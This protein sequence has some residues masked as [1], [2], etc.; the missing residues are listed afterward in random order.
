MDTNQSLKDNTI[1]LANRSKITITGVT[2]VVSISPSAIDL[3]AYGSGLVVLGSD[4][5][6]TK[7]NVETGD[8]EATGRFDAI[9]YS[10]TNSKSNF[11]KRIFK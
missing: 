8:I 7:L 4:I 3:V 1:T 9:R 2:K 5:L 10:N 11:I 6:V